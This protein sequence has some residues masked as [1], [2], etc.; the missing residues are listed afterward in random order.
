MQCFEKNYSCRITIKL[1]RIYVS[2][3]TISI[4]IS[5]HYLWFLI[6]IYVAFL[7]RN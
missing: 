1:D 5:Q 6:S 7:S 2:T 3:T 4:A